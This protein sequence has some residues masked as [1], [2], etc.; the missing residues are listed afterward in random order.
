MEEKAATATTQPAQW[1]N[2]TFIVT[3]LLIRQ[4]W[5]GHGFAPKEVENY[6]NIKNHIAVRPDVD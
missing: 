2:R 4:V 6:E 1:I 5:S 3:M